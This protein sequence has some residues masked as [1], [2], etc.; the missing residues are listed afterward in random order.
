MDALP[1]EIRILLFV[2]LAA[3]VAAGVCLPAPKRAPS[4]RLV[5][6]LAA[7]SVSAFGASAFCLLDGHRAA[8][9]ITVTVFVHL[10]VALMWS[11]RRRSDEG[12]PGHDEGGGGWDDGPDP[13]PEG[14]GGVLPADWWD[15]FSRDF[16][17]HVESRERVGA[18]R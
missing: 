6:A 12:P 17:A 11:T 10:T 15:G 9:A 8:A 2:T 1:L 18:G 13:A 4:F 16:W 3:S 7:L 5:I 14:D